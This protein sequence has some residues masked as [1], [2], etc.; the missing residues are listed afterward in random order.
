MNDENFKALERFYANN[1]KAKLFDK[2]KR[3]EKLSFKD[4]LYLLKDALLTELP[5]EFISSLPTGLGSYL[6]QLYFRKKL[7]KL[8]KNCILSK[9]INFSGCD[10]ISIDD[11]TWIDSGVS[12]S[13]YFGYID[14]GKRVHISPNSIISGGG[15]VQIEDYVG[16]ASGVQIYSH[17]QSPQKGKFMSGPMVLIEESGFK[18]EKVICEEHS[19]IGA[20]SI[21][22]PGVTIGRG[23]M[24]GALSVV[25]KSIEP[26]SIYI[27]NPA[28][29]IGKRPKI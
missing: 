1:K 10:Y 14:I 24:V 5:S 22:L 19:F 12:L 27:G 16:I 2:F 18:T 17:S 8:G 23:A 20:G 3:D 15:G 25:Y 21:I 26:W 6:R 7:K 4:N 29:K 28:K 11:F 13:C 9:N